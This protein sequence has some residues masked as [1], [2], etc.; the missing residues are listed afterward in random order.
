VLV[1]LLLVY[2]RYIYAT[3]S[4]PAWWL[5]ACCEGVAIIP[6]RDPDRSSRVPKG[7]KTLTDR[8]DKSRVNPRV[9]EHAG[10]DDDDDAGW[11]GRARRRT[12]LVLPTQD[13]DSIWKIILV[14]IRNQSMHAYAIQRAMHGSMPRFG[15]L[16][17]WHGPSSIHGSKS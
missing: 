13:R 6:S 7:L 2:S 9:R 11:C 3:P 10:S 12:V 4:N 5:A 15:G 16:E 14:V 8:W 17:S 1:L